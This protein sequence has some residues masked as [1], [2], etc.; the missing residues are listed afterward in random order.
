[1]MWIELVGGEVKEGWSADRMVDGGGSR[2][3]G[4]EPG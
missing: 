1:M 4:A 3:E 2:W